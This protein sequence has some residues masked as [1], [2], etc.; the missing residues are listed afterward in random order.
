MSVHVCMCMSAF[1][2]TFVQ[3]MCAH[4]SV[5][6]CVRDECIHIELCEDVNTRTHTHRVLSS[7]HIIKVSCKMRFKNLLKMHSQTNALHTHSPIHQHCGNSIR[8]LN[9]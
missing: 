6:V 7:Q 5:H 1:T 8:P 2:K 3:C 4:V 9:A